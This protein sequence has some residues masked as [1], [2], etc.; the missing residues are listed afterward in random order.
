MRKRAQLKSKPVVEEPK[1]VAVQSKPKEE[2]KIS[3]PKRKY[4]VA[5]AL[6]AIF[7]MVLFFIKG[8]L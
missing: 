3:L 2:K 7:F 6:I 1:H 4:W 5:L 8:Y